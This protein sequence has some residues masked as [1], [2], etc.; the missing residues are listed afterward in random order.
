[1]SIVGH[2]VTDT[3]VTLAGL[4][5]QLDYRANGRTL[6]SLGLDGCAPCEIV[7][8]LIGGADAY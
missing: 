4:L 3:V 6:D 7:R 8:T 2:E 5:G 1:L